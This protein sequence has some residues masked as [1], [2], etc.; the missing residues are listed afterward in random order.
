MKLVNGRGVC[1]TLANKV[2]GA[3][4]LLSLLANKVCGAGFAIFVS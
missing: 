1:G 3:R 4:D 2:C